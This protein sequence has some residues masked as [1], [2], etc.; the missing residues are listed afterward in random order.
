[1]AL[2]CCF[3]WSYYIYGDREL[4]FLLH[5]AGR[6]NKLHSRNVQDEWPLCPWDKGLDGGIKMPISVGLEPE[7]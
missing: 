1:M 2:R 7:C 3:P 6:D 4:I 5:Y